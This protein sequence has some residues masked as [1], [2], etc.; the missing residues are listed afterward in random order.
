CFHARM[1]QRPEESVVCSVRLQHRSKIAALYR[2]KFIC[3]GNKLFAERGVED[4]R[5]YMSPPPRIRCERIPRILAERT[6]G[7]QGRV[8]NSSELYL[9]ESVLYVMTQPEQF[10]LPPSPSAALMSAIP[11]LSIHMT[12]NRP[13]EFAE[14]LDRLER[15]T[16]V[17]SSVEVV[18]KIDDM[19]E[20]MHRLL[21]KEA[22]ARPFRVRYISTP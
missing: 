4:G 18:I 17:P 6:I 20:A 16:L 9:Q 3:D 10:S 1:P 11:L 12:S 8:R 2:G 7:H 5:L 13:R 21:E 22:R 19:D 15:A 14:F